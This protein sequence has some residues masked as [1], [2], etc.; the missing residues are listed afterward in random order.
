MSRSVRDSI[1]LITLIRSL[2]SGYRSGESSRAVMRL[3]IVSSNSCDHFSMWLILIATFLCSSKRA[4][5]LSLRVI[6]S[7][8]ANCRPAAVSNVPCSNQVSSGF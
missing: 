4:E 3:A 6:V 1:R 8:S 7:V 5:S 2:R